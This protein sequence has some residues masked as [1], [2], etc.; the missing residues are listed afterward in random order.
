MNT[1]FRQQSS[2]DEDEEKSR[3]STIAAMSLALCQLSPRVTIGL[4]V[5]TL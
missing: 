2:S 1:L 3:A 4:F 5:E